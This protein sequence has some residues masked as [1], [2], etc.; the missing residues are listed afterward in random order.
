MIINNPNQCGSACE[1]VSIRVSLC[2]V[3]RTR[4]C[5]STRHI[6]VTCAVVL[7]LM[8]L[9]VSLLGRC[10]ADVAARSHAVFVRQKRYHKLVVTMTLDFTSTHRHNTSGGVTRSGRRIR[11]MFLIAANMGMEWMNRFERA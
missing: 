8:M 4:V 1:W 6:N 2:V 3:Q 9:S 11:R 10:R 7:L 5:T